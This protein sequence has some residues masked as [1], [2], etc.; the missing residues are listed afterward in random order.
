MVHLLP[1][2]RLQLYKEAV[3][4]LSLMADC[5]LDHNLCQNFR[6]A[7]Q[8]NPNLPAPD[9]PQAGEVL[10]GDGDQ[11]GGEEEHPVE[12]GLEGEIHEQAVGEVELVTEVVEV[13][14]SDREGEKKGNS[15]EGRKKAKQPSKQKRCE[16]KKS[17]F[18]KCPWP[19]NHNSKASLKSTKTILNLAVTEQYGTP[20]AGLQVITRRSY[21]DML[22]NNKE[23]VVDKTD[24]KLIEL[25]K[26]ITERLTANVFNEEGEDIIGHTKT[27][28]DLPDLAMKIK[29]QV[30]TIV[31]TIIEFPKWLTAVKKIKLEDLENVPET[32]LKTQFKLFVERLEVLTR[33]YSEIDLKKLDSKVLIKRFFDPQD[34]LF[35]DIEMVMHAMA[36]ASVKHSCE[37]ILESFVSEYENHF[38]EHRNVDETT[39]NEEFEIAVNGPNLA[40]ADAVILQAM[41]VYWDGKPWHFYRTSPLENLVNPTGVSSTLKRLASVK[42]SLPIMD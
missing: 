29:K 42:N 2:E 15:L 32:E 14:Q 11:H 25:T 19:K 13:I 37:S 10:D 35:E 41:D 17:A 39:A 36:V 6:S 38:D 27:I 20:A 24:K 16:K 40:H 23:N 8:Q 33:N 1:Y 34:K 22:V 28:L 5:L 9:Q 12:H 7:C 31:L 4:R 30:S 18:M 26:D 3:R 21:Q